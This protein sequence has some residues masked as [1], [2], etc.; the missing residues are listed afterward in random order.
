MKRFALIGA[1]GYIA[2]RHLQAIH[3]VGGILVAAY[4]PSDSVGHL[5]AYFP[6]AAFFTEFER[7]DRHLNKLAESGEAVEYI[8]ICSPNYL[9]DSHIRY[10]LRNGAHCICEKPIT[11][12]PWNVEGLTATAQST[13]KQ[14][15]T[16]LQLRLHEQ[17]IALREKV[18]EKL[19]TDPHYI[20]DVDLTYITSRGHWYYASWKGDEEKS[21]GIA[22][23]IGVH[24]FDMLQWIFG[25]PE[26]QKVYVRSH[27]RASGTI[28]FSNA[29]IRWFLSIN[30]QTLPQG[31]KDAG[32]KTFRSLTFD[33]WSFDFSE[34]FTDLH[35]A[36]YDH[37]LNGAGFSE[38]DAQ[39][40]IAMVHEMRELPLLEW[41]NEA[42]EL[43]AL[44]LAPHPF[45]KNR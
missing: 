22:T 18:Q 8:S 26:V 1:A 3:E 33:Q 19:A 40:A 35:T 32:K 9:H 12:R 34:G 10:A 43:A 24:F 36:S 21:G 5:D 44:P 28:R 2:P 13:G 15:F 17:V 11:L 29:N 4:D 42:H 25:A 30:A 14:I 27:D 38:I 16:I 45:K 39:N 7:F 23:N 6:E 37:I 41:D 20:F 31:A